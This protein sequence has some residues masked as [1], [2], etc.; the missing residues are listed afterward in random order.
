[1]DNKAKAIEFLELIIKGEIDEAFEGFVNYS[2]KHHNTYFK[3]GFES[4]KYA[5]KQNHSIFPDKQFEIKLATAEG[6]LVSIL[7]KL[8]FEN[9]AFIASYYFKF[10]ENKILE[11]WDIVQEIPQNIINNDGPL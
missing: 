7:A 9:K 3:A 4:L 5:M 11:M 10:E 6:E 1:M 2:G 8:A